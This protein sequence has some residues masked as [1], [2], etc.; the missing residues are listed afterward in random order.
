MRLL[1]SA[2]NCE[3]LELTGCI[4][5]TEYFLD[6]LF[7]EYQHLKFIDVNH[8]PAMTPALFEVVKQV[9][10]DIYIRRFNITEVDPNDNMLRIPWRVI[11]K[12]GKKKKK[13]KKK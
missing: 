3:H 10:P 11:Q 9:R 4:G 12:E 5:L 2:P 7:R 13:K 6:K 8:I 1:K